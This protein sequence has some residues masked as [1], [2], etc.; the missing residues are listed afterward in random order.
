MVLR[1]ADVDRPQVTFRGT[2]SECMS[3]TT[4]LLDEGD[5]E[6]MSGT[7]GLLSGGGLSQTRRNAKRVCFRMCAFSFDEA[8]PV[9]AENVAL[10]G[11]HSVALP[12]CVVPL[13]P[14]YL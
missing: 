11:V 9:T 8:I 1:V 4:G 3:C 2:V 14:F 7:T 6:C 13:E 12:L 5:C 10:L